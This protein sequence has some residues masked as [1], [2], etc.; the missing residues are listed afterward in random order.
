MDHAFSVKNQRRFPQIRTDSKEVDSK[1]TD[2]SLVR[3]TLLSEE[4]TKRVL[5]RNSRQWR[6]VS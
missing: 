1:R 3:E 5:R 6:S 4:F 2:P